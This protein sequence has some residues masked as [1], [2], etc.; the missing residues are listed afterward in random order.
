MWRHFHYLL[1]NTVFALNLEGLLCLLFSLGRVTKI[2]KKRY[3]CYLLLA[4]FIYSS[5]TLF[6]DDF[7]TK[8]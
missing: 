7:D 2:D 4:G 8:K 6:A 1:I 3:L 5:G